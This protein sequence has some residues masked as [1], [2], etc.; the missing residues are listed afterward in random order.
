MKIYHQ[1][2]GR[3]NKKSRGKCRLYDES[4]MD[5]GFNWCGPEDEPIPECMICGKT[6]TNESKVLVRL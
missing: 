4:Y 5:I 2:L 1:L 6:L 3:Q